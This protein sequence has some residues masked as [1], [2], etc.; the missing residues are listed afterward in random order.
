MSPVPTSTAQES[1]TNAASGT[2]SVP[3]ESTQRPEGGVQD[4]SNEAL[5]FAA[6]VRK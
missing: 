1:Q 4:L 6:K 2:S 3:S 5:D